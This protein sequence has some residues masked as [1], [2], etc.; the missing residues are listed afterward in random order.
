[1]TIADGEGATGAKGFRG[2]AAR[3][4][5]TVFLTLVL[6]AGWLILGYMAAAHHG[7][8]PGKQIPPPLFILALQYLALLPA[9][10]WVTWAG[11]G[12]GAVKAL[13]ARA[14]RWR[15]G[16][17]W[18]ALAVLGLPLTTVA[19]GLLGGGTFR[20]VDLGPF[21]L[22]QAVSIGSAVLLINL[23][24]ETA[25]SGFLQTRLERRHNIVIASLLTA[26]PFA[27]IHLPLAF[28]NDDAMSTIIAIALLAGCAPLVRLLFA[29]TLR[30][31]RDSVLAVGIL[32]AMWNGTDSSSGLTAGLLS[33]VDAL[34][35]AL[36]AVVV[37]TL[38]A[39][40]F[41]WGRLSKAYR[42]RTFAAAPANP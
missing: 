12:M 28:M 34:S 13:L 37:L 9:A 17:G 3:R 25:W 39:V 19:I 8:V 15:F 30:G 11:E 41:S 22:G 38:V 36:L 23:W 16:L 20:P 10:L 40:L 7:L 21:L 14:V 27:G 5:I 6:G 42:A 35:C 4:P 32:H 2:L 26:I 24:E 18:W 33:G 1:M 29:T 31:A